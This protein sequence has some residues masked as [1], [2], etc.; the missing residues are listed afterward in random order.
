[1]LKIQDYLR[2]DGSVEA[3]TAELGIGVYRHPSLPLIGFK[4]QSHAPKAH[5]LVREARGLVL[6]EGS[7]EVVAKPFDRFFNAGEG[8]DDL[9]NFNWSRCSCQAKEDGALTIVY[10]YRGEWHVNSSGGFGHGIV[11]FARMSWTQLFWATTGLDPSRFDGRYTYIFE[12]CS[13]YTKIVRLY[14][15]P[16]FYLLSMFETATCRELSHEAVD[17]EAARIGLARPELFPCA[18]MG[19]VA[20]FL[21]EKERDDPTFEGVVIRD[22]RDL[23]FKI[24]TKTYLAAHHADDGGNLFHPRRLVPL[25]LADEADEL[26]AYHPELRETVARVKERLDRAWDEVRAAWEENWRIEDQ[27]DFATAIIRA[28]PFSGLLFALRKELGARQS[29]EDVRRH[30]CANAESI[31]KI[32]FERGEGR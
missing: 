6:E 4:Y 28:T 9:A 12:L 26:V 32:L 2:G 30:W 25:I 11:S 23:R 17:E 21:L 10:P 1:M 3:L 27:R 8:V 15:S 20:A 7:W 13:P 5:P 16:T 29:V 18:S 14:P 22:D 19:E 31:V 24:K